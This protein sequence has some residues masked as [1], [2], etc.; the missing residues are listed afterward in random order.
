MIAAAREAG[1]R[2]TLLDTCYLHGGFGEP[3][4]PVQERFSDGRR[5]GL[6]RARRRA[7]RPSRARASARRSTACG[8][9]T[10]TPARPS[11]TGP[12]S[13]SVRCTPTSPSSRPR[14]RPAVAAY[15]AHAD[16][17]ARR[18]GRSGTALHRRPRDAPRPTPTSAALG[19][20]RCMLL[21]VPDHRARPRRRD[22]PGPGARRCGRRARARHRLARRD[23]H[24]RGGARGGA[25]RATCDR[26]A[27]PPRRRGAV[28]GRDAPPAT[29]RSAGPRRARSSRARSP[30]W[31]RS[32]STGCGSPGR[33]ADTAL[34]AVVFAAAA[35][36]VEAGGLRRARDRAR[37]RAPGARRCRRAA[38][39]DRRGDVVSAI[40]I[41]RIG[42]LVTNDPEL[43][44]GPLGIVRDAALVI[45]DGR[46]AA[47]EP[48][49][50]GADE[51][52]DA[53]GRCV[54]P[55]FVDSHTHLVFAGDRADEFAARMAGQPYEAGGIAVTT[56]G[57]AGGERGRAP[58]PRP[59]PAAP[60]ASPPGS[61]R[62]RSSP[63]TGS[64]STPEERLCRVAAELTD[65]VTFLGGH[66]LPPEYEGRAD[67]YV[68][69][70]CGPML[71]ACRP[72]RPLDRRVLRARRVRR[73]PVARDAARR[74]RSGPRAAR[75]RQPA[76][77]GSGGA[78]RGRARRRLGRSLHL[79]RG[80]GHRGAGGEATRSPP[81]CRRRTSP[82]ASPIRTRAGRSTPGSRSRSRPTPT[83][84]RATRPRCRS[85]SRSPCATWG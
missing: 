24:A 30:T 65:E 40:A 59:R 2:I 37:R 28:A 49:G 77:P 73:R 23:R 67:E 13:A 12:A 68:E 42:L 9:S 85:A 16:R 31:S 22:R 29:P 75:A 3:L 20:G 43:G 71:D 11:R 18:R 26:R 6:G 66:L 79:S 10:R 51:R 50:A 56:D 4:N 74:P 69:L 48:A 58:G 82:P 64:R 83:R 78:A 17:R 61:P 45:E 54:I 33:I 21:S 35:A 53:A 70:V 1:I 47:I 46:V 76:R 34:E 38:G 15:G 41:D 44:E 84:A 52:F 55:G 81:S 14:T 32:T 36:D 57:D 63:A 7:R 25:R 72:V 27:R 8:P 62:W 60:R 5:R 19:G 39:V 80:R